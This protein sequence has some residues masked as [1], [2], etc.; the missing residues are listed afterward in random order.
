MAS[1]RLPQLEVL[2]QDEHLVAVSKPAGLLA[3]RSAVD[4]SAREFALQAARDQVGRDVFLAHRLD[5]PTSGVL[6][7]ALSS[8]VV[9]ALYN[10]FAERR[11]RKEYLA[12]VRGHL[13]GEGAVDL[14]LRVIRDR[15]VKRGA[16]SAEL[17]DAR[18]CYRS[19]AHA[20]V[21][22]PAGR[23]S[24]VRLTLLELTPQTGRRHQLRRHMAK[25]SH[26]IIGDTMYGDNQ[27]NKA[28]RENLGATRLMLHARRLALQHPVTN[29]QL[30]ITA[31]LDEQFRHVLRAAGFGDWTEGMATDSTALG[32]NCFETTS[33]KR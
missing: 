22:Y 14:P 20:E 10:A 1:P 30:T 28:A 18:T 25:I 21:P 26:P 7:L 16:D 4:R 6:L 19:L 17:Q 13:G 32:M 9:R 29:E 33:S 27:Q 23:Y 8:E 11:V 2:F 5:K 15:N 24:T 31:G 3:H 12:V